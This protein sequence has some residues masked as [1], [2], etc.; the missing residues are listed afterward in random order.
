M[1]F[2]GTIFIII[3]QLFVFFS[4]IPRHLIDFYI[5][6][7]AKNIVRK[8]RNSFVTLLIDIVDSTEDL[9]FFVNGN[10]SRGRSSLGIDNKNTIL[11][12]MP[13]PKS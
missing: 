13:A 1:I 11:L 4:F 3:R 8:S 9:S 2:F 5:C 7:E 12:V 6:D 10:F